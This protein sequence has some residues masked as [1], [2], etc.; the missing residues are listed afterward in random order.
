MA[1]RVVTIAA[2][3]TTIEEGIGYEGQDGINE[4][5][6]PASLLTIGESVFARCGIKRIDLSH[7]RVTDIGAYAFSGCI[8]LTEVIL[9]D[10]LVG[11][12]MGCFHSC[13]NITAV[14][15][16]TTNVATVAISTFYGCTS[17]AT[18]KMPATL[19]D[20]G[21]RSFFDCRAL[22]GVEFPNGLTAI[23][24]GAFCLC[25]AL[26]DLRI[27][28]SVATMGGWAFAQCTALQTVAM[29]S[30]DVK[31]TSYRDKHGQFSGCTSL[32]AIS[33]PD[34]NHAVATWTHNTMMMFEDCPKQLPVLLAAATADMQLQYYWKPGAEGHA[35]CRP[36]ARRAVLTVLLVAVRLMHAWCASADRH[37]QQQRR[38]HRVAFQARHKVLPDL[39]D[40]LWFCILRLI[41][42]HKLGGASA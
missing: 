8:S 37:G 14:D 4:A 6:F 3:T 15:L 9:P 12:G 17:L 40:E 38:S 26:T 16:S 21:D 10:T 36:S 33:V 2:G 7:T 22:T 18:V 29:E 28:A 11:M 20:I 35:L 30:T 1:D 23:G 31:F 42:R 27:P 39:P 5:I 24:K 19:T 13:L 41:R 25:S 34:A 32:A